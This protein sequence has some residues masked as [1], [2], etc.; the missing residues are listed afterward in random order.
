[1]NSTLKIIILV[2]LSEIECLYI[3]IIGIAVIMKIFI[4]NICY[5][6]CILLVILDILGFKFDQIIEKFNITKFSMS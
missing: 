6:Y 3:N 4:H 1:M 5:D 2:I